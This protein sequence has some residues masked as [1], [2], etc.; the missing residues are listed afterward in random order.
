[1]TDSLLMGDPDPVSLQDLTP[2]PETG[3]ITK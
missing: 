2:I 1:L 3:L